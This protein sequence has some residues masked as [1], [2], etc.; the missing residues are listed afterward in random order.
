MITRELAQQ[1]VVFLYRLD[2]AAA[3]DGDAVLGAF[4]L[5]QQVL[6]QAVGLQLRVVLG[7]YQQARKRRAQFA[8]GLL[9]AL[10]GLLVVQLVGVQLHA[11]D[12]G[13]GSVTWVRTDA[14]W[15]A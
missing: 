12:L 3:S 9:E 5:G 11:A 8:L 4:Q 1:H 6:E 13:P 2:V 10:H 7:D 14:S 15:E